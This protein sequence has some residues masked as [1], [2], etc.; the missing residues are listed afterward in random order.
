MLTT[1]EDD[2]DAGWAL[3]TLSVD[4][5]TA[6]SGTSGSWF[7]LRDSIRLVDASQTDLEVPFGNILLFISL[8]YLLNRLFGRIVCVVPLP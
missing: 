5:P 2:V 6:I 7:A 3:V 1:V 8:S 4:C